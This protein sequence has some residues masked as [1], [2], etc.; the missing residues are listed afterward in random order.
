MKKSILFFPRLICFAIFAFLLLQCKKADAPPKPA[1]ELILGSWVMKS[2]AYN[3]A[4][5]FLG[6]GTKITDLF[7][8]FPAC[9]QDDIYTFKTSGQGVIDESTTKCDAADPQTFPFTWELK[10]N[11]TILYVDF[12]AEDYTIVQLDNTTGK[13]SRTI[14]EAGIT[15]T[16]TIVFA[17]K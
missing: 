17:R 6:N 4:Y 1:S 13:L 8:Q 7:A 14:I 15:Y 10:N 5:D 9:F 3:P 16:E 2:Y 11:N 12:L